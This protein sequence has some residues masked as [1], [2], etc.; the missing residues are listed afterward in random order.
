MQVF[1]TLID[2]EPLLGGIHTTIFAY[3]VT[4]EFY[5]TVV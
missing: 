5:K 4:G 1:N 2:L 3:G